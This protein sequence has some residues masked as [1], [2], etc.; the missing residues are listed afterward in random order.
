[1]ATAAVVAGAGARRAITSRLCGWRGG[2]GAELIS[3]EDV[4]GCGRYHGR[5]G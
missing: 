5:R 3:M 2:R 4:G 1:M